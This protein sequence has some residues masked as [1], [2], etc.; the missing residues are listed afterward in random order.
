MVCKFDNKAGH[1]TNHS[2]LVVTSTCPKIRKQLATTNLG[3]E[4][5]PVFPKVQTV[6]DL[7]GDTLNVRLAPARGP[8]D[9]RILY[10]LE[11]AKRT[12]HVPG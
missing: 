11:A 12:S 5:Q 6:A 8:S 9:A 4:E 1:H 2:K 3:T 10:V 7:V